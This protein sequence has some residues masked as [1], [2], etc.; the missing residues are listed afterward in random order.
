MQDMFLIYKFE[1]IFPK[2]ILSEK[3]YYNDIRVRLSLK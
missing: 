2:A 3:S 1:Y